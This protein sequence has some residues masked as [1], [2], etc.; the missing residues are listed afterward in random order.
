MGDRG[1]TRRAI[2][3]AAVICIAGVALASG[4]DA[5]PTTTITVKDPIPLGTLDGRGVTS[6]VISPDGSRAYA[7]VTTFVIEP[8]P[9][10]PHLYVIDTTSD[11]IVGTLEISGSTTTQGM[12]L[13]PDGDLLYIAST[14][15]N[16]V[17]V[18]DTETLQIVGAFDAARVEN[19]VLSPDGTFLAVSG[20]GLSIIRRSDGAT[21]VSGGPSAGAGSISWATTP[22]GLPRLFMGGTDEDVIASVDLVEQDGSWTLSQPTLIDFGSRGY[23]LA[24]SPQA[25]VVFAASADGRVAV[26]DASSLKVT[27]ELVGHA[28]TPVRALA[29]SGDGKWLYLSHGEDVAAISVATGSRST[30]NIERAVWAIAVSP[31]DRGG[32]LGVTYSAE[33]LP[34]AITHRAKVTVTSVAPDRIPAGVAT[35]I[36]LR[37]AGFS[38]GKTT[39]T[40]GKGKRTWP[41]RMVKVRSSGALWCTTPALSQGSYRVLV[42]VSGPAGGKASLEDAFTVSAR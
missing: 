4:A 10:E 16:V 30:T 32:F 6:V 38:S 23:R 18:V 31:G 3:L 25:N 34:I 27:K 11:E 21:L 36:A 1:I 41:C 29:V 37:G 8:G 20:H 14:G 39:V 42:S 24:T 5:E 12:A 9:P 33:L 22:A 15:L 13:S 19:V 26:I 28:N 7:F 17:S 2:G 40:L 35:K